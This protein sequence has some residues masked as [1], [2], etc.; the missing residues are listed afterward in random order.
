VQATFNI[1][2]GYSR[3]FSLSN[4]VWY[5]RGMATSKT[6]TAAQEK[7]ARHEVIARLGGK[8]QNPDCSWINADGTR[9]CTDVRCLQVDYK[10]PTSER[11]RSWGKY[12]KML[13]EEKFF[14]RYQA[15]CANCNSI[16]RVTVGRANPSLRETRFT[17]GKGW[18][19]KVGEMWIPY[20]P[21]KKEALTAGNVLAAAIGKK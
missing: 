18:E 15:L 13:K 9:G 4:W 10:I 2:E 17:E 8:C 5:P 11:N 1:R 20:Q 14:E 19:I 16:A 21:H 3:D 12:T 6:T 7:K